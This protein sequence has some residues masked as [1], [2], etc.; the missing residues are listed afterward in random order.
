MGRDTLKVGDR[1]RVDPVWSF[2]SG[3]GV[4]ES[5]YTD[6]YQVL[7]DKT[8][9]GKDVGGTS[10]YYNAREVTLIEEEEPSFPVE[11]GD[12]IRVLHDNAEGTD[13]ECGAVLT[14][15]E[16]FDR[17]FYTDRTGET[18]TWVWSI[19]EEDNSWERIEELTENVLPI[20]TITE[21]TPV[22][23]FDTGARRDTTEGKSRPDLIPGDVILRIGHHFAMGAE[24]Y[25]ERNF[26]KGI[27]S[28][29]TQAS[30]CRH[31]EQ[32]KSGDTSEDHLA[33]IASNTIFLMFNENKFEG[34]RTI[35][36]LERYSDN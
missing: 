10:W 12:K 25:G 21:T 8:D 27:P 33:A 6:A 9:S 3:E 4:I 26:E 34:D 35:L 30:L 31:L 1:V 11:V 28:S 22:Q 2:G 15:T 7:V 13:E 36:D 19:D 14:V 23:T 17:D 5:V 32:F 16:L 20:E 18:G 29:R 24:K